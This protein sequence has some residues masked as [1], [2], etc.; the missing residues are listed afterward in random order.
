MYAFSSKWAFSF[1]G[2]FVF[3]FTNSAFSNNR[4][5]VCPMKDPGSLIVQP[6][7]AALGSDGAYTLYFQQRDNAGVPFYC[8]T[9]NLGQIAPVI[10]T[11]PGGKVILKL[12]NLTPPDVQGLT[13]SVSKHGCGPDPM[14]PSS[15]NMHFHGTFLKPKCRQDDV[16]TTAV[17]SGNTLTY[18]LE[19]AENHPPGLYW[20]HYHGLQA[21]SKVFASPGLLI[22]E[23][24]ENYRPEVVG[25][26]E[27]FL[28]L[29]D[30]AFVGN[31]NDSSAP[32]WDM[33]VN[34]VQ[35]LYQPNGP[36]VSP[37]MLLRPK[38]KYVLSIAA[39]NSGVTFDASVS[40]DGVT[41]NLEL[42]EL[43][44]VPLSKIQT[45]KNVF[46]VPGARARVILTSPDETVQNATIETLDV[47]TGNDGDYN[48]KR[49]LAQI[50]LDTN[51]AESDYRFPPP[52]G[53]VD[54][55]TANSIQTLMD[56]PATEL[57]SLIFTE[58]D[59]SFFL[60]PDGLEPH[61]YDPTDPPAITTTVGS[62]HVWTISNPT[63]EIHAF[64]PHG[65]HFLVI[66][67][68]GVPVSRSKLVWRDSFKV[69]AWSGNSSDPIPSFKAK[70][71]F[72]KKDEGIFPM[73]CHYLE[74][75]DGGM[76][77]NIA[78]NSASSIKPAFNILMGIGTSLGLMW[79]QLR[80]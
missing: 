14:T 31:S 32:A 43:D 16:L 47:N 10:R 49:P 69:D 2:A 19:F 28:E 52:S 8:Y 78:V 55:A 27:K 63:Q 46:L 17:R 57:H 45:V 62:V 29:R 34:H 41:Q 36:F 9:D 79:N 39:M 18:S 33:S 74:H 76:G 20:Y 67:E 53:T 40:Y 26:P 4:L 58:D 80:R 37:Q 48:P 25:L 73:H 12:V 56:A 30:Q 59:S 21:E 11:K 7:T 60:T 65:I 13:L 66:E 38:Q 75:A 42:V 24:L 22:V 51:A 35:V 44:G 64:H 5:S 3:C 71:Q 6:P 1:L 77:F 15:I 68:N 72:V 50:V 54:P 23:G 61:A 70:I